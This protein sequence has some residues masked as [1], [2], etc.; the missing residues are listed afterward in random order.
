MSLLTLMIQTQN[1]MIMKNILKFEI[2]IVACGFFSCNDDLNEISNDTSSD[3]KNTVLAKNYLNF[4]RTKSAEGS[5]LIQSSTSNAMQDINK[6]ITFAEKKSRSN[7]KKGSSNKRIEIKDFDNNTSSKRMK[8]S[9]KDDNSFFGKVL[10]YRVVDN[11]QLSKNSSESNSYDEVYIPEL[12]N[13]TYSTAKLVHGTVINWNIDSFNKNGVIISLEYYAVNQLDTKLAFD[14]T[15]TI[16]KSFVID[17]LKG[18]YTI[19]DEDLEMFPNKALLDINVLRAGFNT[20]ENSNL[21]IAGLTKIGDTK[22][23]EH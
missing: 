5:V 18:S 14:N 11:S 2:I 23:L 3:I 6:N 20:D 22:I 16:K 12:I 21:A 1:K 13:V 19:T 10:L 17:D 4:F 8:N 7:S 15:T 9:T